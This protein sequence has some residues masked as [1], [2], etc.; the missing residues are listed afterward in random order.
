MAGWE[1]N[2]GCFK[3][4]KISDDEIWSTINHIFSAK[5][6]KTT[7]YKY[8][9]LKSILDNIFNVDD[10]LNIGFDKIFLR[11]TEVYWNLIVRHKLCQIQANSRQKKSSVEIVIEDFVKKYSFGEDFA[12]EGLRSDLQLELCKKVGAQC[13]KYVIG[14]FFVDTK[15]TFYSFNKNKKQLTYN[16]Y[17]YTILVKY[18][19]V[20]EKLNYFEWIKFL[21]KVNPRESSYAIAEKLDYS[22]KRSN[23]SNYKNYLFNENQQHKCF[24]CNTSI[25][26]K[27]I[28]VDHYIPWSFVKDDKLW[29]FV[30]SCR[31]CNNSKRDKLP[32]AIYTNQIIKR[33]EA[34]IKQDK[35][36]IVKADFEGY[37]NEKIISMYNSA[38]FNGFDYDWKPKEC[39]KG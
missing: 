19:H 38:I 31:D 8:C 16:P 23:L 13:S 25:T 14:A 3:E 10:N 18:K 33:N 6:S 34:I 20:I 1:L 4:G 21:E 15:E 17:V 11:F 5:S 35:A 2:E 27:A 28:E 9:F 7:T 37:R 39:R 22:A 26:N 24:Y 32:I 36:K 12:F 30:L 29:N